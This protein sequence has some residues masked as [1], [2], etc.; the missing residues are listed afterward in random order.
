MQAQ[1]EM[2]AVTTNLAQSGAK[3]LQVKGAIVEP[4]KTTSWLCPVR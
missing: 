2:A 1:D 3:S 4:P